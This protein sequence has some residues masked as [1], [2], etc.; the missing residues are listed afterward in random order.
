MKTFTRNARLNRIIDFTAAIHKL[1]A[2]IYN[3]YETTDG[4]R[5]MP[6]YTGDGENSQFYASRLLMQDKLLREINK[7]IKLAYGTESEYFIS[8]NK[9]IFHKPVNDPKDAPLYDEANLLWRK[10]RRELIVLIADMLAEETERAKL[11]EDQSQAL[12]YAGFLVVF[13]IS[14]LT[15]WFAPKELFSAVFNL[16]TLLAAR[17]CLSLTIATMSM[18]I[19]APNKWKE[20]IGISLIPFVIAILPFLKTEKINEIK[21]TPENSR[22]VIDT[23]ENKLK[24]LSNAD[25][26]GTKRKTIEPK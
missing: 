20:L 13:L 21:R 8:V 25:G 22:I 11:G 2:D 10:G 3:I 4:E 1:P 19:L 16:E 5:I 6:Y 26:N 9:I 7:F 12:R 24:H 14:L 18:T 15:I 17:V 23:L